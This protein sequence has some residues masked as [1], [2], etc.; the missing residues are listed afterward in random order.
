MGHN[1][2]VSSREKLPRGKAGLHCLRTKGLRS[3][4]IPLLDVCIQ[5]ARSAA[6]IKNPVGDK[7]TPFNFSDG[8]EDTVTGC[9]ELA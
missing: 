5:V 4:F 3:G 6:E 2:I 9:I 7:F 1:R 8:N